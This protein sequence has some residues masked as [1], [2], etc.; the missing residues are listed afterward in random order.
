MAELSRTQYTVRNIIVGVGGQA[1]NT[2]LRFL[3]RTFFINYLAVEY[4]GLNSLFTEVLTVLSLAELG[5]GNA[6]AYALYKPLANHDEKQVA[7][8]MNFYKKAYRYIGMAIGTVGMILIPFLEYIV[9]MPENLDINVYVVYSLFLFNSCVSYFFSY[10]QTL[11]NANQKNYIVQSVNMVSGIVKL[12]SQMLVIAITKNFYLYLVV[13]IICTIAA[14]VVIV[15]YVDKKYKFLKKLPREKLDVEMK[16]TL[17]INIKSLFIIKIGSILVN[18]TDNMIISALNGIKSVGL[19]A[20]YTMFTTVCERFLG[21]IFDSMTASIGNLN[22]QN[23]VKKSEDFFHVVNLL[24]YWLFGWATIGI[25]VLANPIIEL[26]I[27]KQYLLSQ[28]IVVIIAINLYVKGMQN[29]IWTYK[30]TYGLFRYGKFFLQVTAILNLILSVILGKKIGLAGV[31][32]ATFISRLCT[33]VWYEP[34]V[35]YRYGFKKEKKWFSYNY[36]YMKYA[37]LLFVSAVVTWEISSLLVSTF[38][39]NNLILQCGI[40]LL[41]VIVIPNAINILFFHRKKEYQYIKGKVIHK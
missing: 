32:T 27:G 31:L 25:I 11:L 23:D 7:K 40:K 33:N 5:I 3:N 30:N 29:G 35:V 4:L 16:K 14:N 21:Q 28:T 36:T 17:S 24:N 39:M 34:Y 6:I 41:C 8:L 9:D 2:L 13:Q 18:S 22:A 10:K 15:L 12:V 26:W 38:Q 1:V 37:V 20:N 19:L